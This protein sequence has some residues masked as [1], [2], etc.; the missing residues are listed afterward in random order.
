MPHQPEPNRRRALLDFTRFTGLSKGELPFWVVVG[1][2]LLASL[3]LTGKLSHAPRQPLNATAVYALLALC[4]LSAG[5]IVG[6]LFGIPH[7]ASNPPGTGPAGQAQPSTSLEQIS[8]WLTKIIIGV[9]LVELRGLEARLAQL[10]ALIGRAVGVP[11]VVPQL[12]VVIFGVL[13]FLAAY[14]WTRIYYSGIQGRADAALRK[15]ELQN[16]A[17]QVAGLQGQ[18]AQNATTLEKQSQLQAADSAEQHRLFGA[19]ARSA[20]AAPLAA[21]AATPG[22]PQ[23]RATL[24]PDDPALANWNRKLA[25]FMAA[26]P[27]WQ[28]DPTA[29]I[30]GALPASTATRHLAVAVLWRSSTGRGLYLQA[31]VTGQAGAPLTGEVV[32]LLH[33]TYLANR[34]RTVLVKPEANP[35]AGCATLSFY[36]EGSF[37]LVAMTDAGHT[38]LSYNL[39][40]LGPGG[41]W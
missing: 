25:E 33:P 31:D 8:D 30:F 17:S 29:R 14:I 23:A 3:L 4:C 41:D 18:V 15:L 36:T 27:D 9:G 35:A 16:L 26:P 11:M 20:A 12:L 22:S 21:A 34:A 5:S 6:F 2:C 19:L 10:G 13:G 37:T 39:K 28:T 1:T 38:L 24:A 40:D 32:F 7:T